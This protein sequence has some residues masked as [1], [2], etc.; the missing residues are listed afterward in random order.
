[1]LC[2]GGVAAPDVPSVAV[3]GAERPVV[4]TCIVGNEKTSD[5]VVLRLMPSCLHACSQ[6]DACHSSCASCQTYLDRFE[7]VVAE[8]NR[9]WKDLPAEGFQVALSLWPVGVE[10]H[11]R[12]SKWTCLQEDCST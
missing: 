10:D 11:L 12:R 9:L 7:A 1:M 3:Q 2:V 5:S 6:N 8:G 4:V